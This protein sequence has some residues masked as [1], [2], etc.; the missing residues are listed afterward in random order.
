MDPSATCTVFL[1][2]DVQSSCCLIFTCTVAFLLP[3]VSPLPTSSAFTL[4]PAIL[5]TYR[6]ILRPDLVSLRFWSRVLTCLSSTCC[7]FLFFILLALPS[8]FKPEDGIQEDSETLAS[9]ILI[10]L[11][12][13]LL[14]LLPHTHIYR[15]VCVCLLE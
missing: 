12:C 3:T 9:F 5:R 10:N 7:L 15:C 1:S 6:L 13:A 8:P 11:V 14:F 2:A 4:M